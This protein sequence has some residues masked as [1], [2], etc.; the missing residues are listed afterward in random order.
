MY[1]MSLRIHNMDSAPP[2]NLQATQGRLLAQRSA[3]GVDLDNTAG[4]AETQQHIFTDSASLAGRSHC[5]QTVG[6]RNGPHYHK[7][8]ITCSLFPSSSAVSDVELG[9]PLATQHTPE[10]CQASQQPSGNKTD[11]DIDI[12]TPLNNIIT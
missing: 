5:P 4:R 8:P 3:A 7:F 2:H 11:T 6:Q 10:N 1:K 12:H 9:V